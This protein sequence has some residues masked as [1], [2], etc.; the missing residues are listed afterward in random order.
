MLRRSPLWSELGVPGSYV[1]GTMSICRYKSSTA[2][3][4]RCKLLQ[5]YM[6]LGLFPSLRDSHVL[7]QKWTDMSPKLM[8]VD[9]FEV[10][11]E[12]FL[13]SGRNKQG[14]LSVVVGVKL[15][16]P[17]PRCQHCLWALE[18]SLSS[19][20]WSPA[21][22]RQSFPFPWAA[23][24]PASL[25]T[26]SQTSEQLFS[27]ADLEKPS[28]GLFYFEASWEDVTYWAD[29]PHSNLL[30]PGEIRKFEKDQVLCS[31]AAA[32]E[33]HVCCLNGGRDSKLSLTRLRLWLCINSGA[34][35]GTEGSKI[36]SFPTT[37]RSSQ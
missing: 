15:D 10:W 27:S 8:K 35:L 36:F 6:W 4:Y 18:H 37:C 23:T 30:K 12:Y 19:A 1:G 33:T 28:E 29:I 31:A 17:F 11:F 9:T 21:A 34:A 25:G 13:G 14:L 24:S 32:S 20:T 2:A 3:P 22:R 5:T 26:Q 16:P 7:W